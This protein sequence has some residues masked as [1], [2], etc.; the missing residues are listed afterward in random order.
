MVG[1]RMKSGRE[2]Q[3]VGRQLKR[4]D[5]RKCWAGSE[6]LQAVDG[7]WNPDAAECQHRRPERSCPTG[8]FRH[9]WTVTASLKSAWWRTS[10]QRSASCSIWPRPRWKTSKCRWRHAQQRSTH[11]VTCSLLSLVH[12]WPLKTNAV[13]IFAYVHLYTHISRRLLTK[14]RVTAVIAE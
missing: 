2:F 5:G 4:P 11:A 13:R 6:V 8:S 12:E 10:S 3:T 1:S 9:R 7:W 14:V